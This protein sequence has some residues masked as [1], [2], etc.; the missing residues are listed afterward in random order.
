MVPLTSTAEEF[1]MQ[2]DIIRKTAEKVFARSRIAWITLVG[3]MIEI[4]HAALTA[5]KIAEHAEFSVLEQMI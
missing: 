5:D 2:E 4:P 3:T 1:E